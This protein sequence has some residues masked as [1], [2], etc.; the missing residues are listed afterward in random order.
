MSNITVDLILPGFPGRSSVAGLGWCS[1]AI[2][3]SGKHSMLVDTGGPGAR[4]VVLQELEKRKIDH[5]DI[6][7]V[8][9]SHMHW[10]HCYNADLFPRAEFVISREEWEYGNLIAS[11]VPSEAHPFQGGYLPW[12][13]SF[14]KKIV[15]GNDEELMPGVTCFATPGHTPGCI[16]LLL[17]QGDEKW[18]IVAD[19]VKN[20]AELTKVDVDMSVDMEKSKSS[21]MKIKKIANRVLPGHDC[22]LRLEDDKVIPEGGNDVTLSMPFGMRV[23]GSE[24]LV[25]HV[26]L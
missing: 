12:L 26:E 14:K 8:F 23:N 24:N 19:S 7:R 16:S 10:D 15:E 21:I 20:R 6:E 2:I 4:R 13:R 18:A 3:R 11:V 25:L 22:W 5:Y 1:V 17:D 9:I